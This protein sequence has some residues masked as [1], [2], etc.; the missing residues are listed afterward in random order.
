MT[1]S[2]LDH[3]LLF[4]Y[5]QYSNLKAGDKHSLSCAVLMYIFRGISSAELTKEIRYYFGKVPVQDF[6]AALMHN[7][8]LLRNVKAYLLY[9]TKRDAYHCY[10]D[11]RH[12][13]E[14]Y[15]IRKRDISLAYYLILSPSLRQLLL[16]YAKQYSCLSLRRI[17]RNLNHITKEVEVYTKKFV[18]RKLRFIYTS[19]PSVEEQDLV[20]ELLSKGVQSVLTMYPCIESMQHAINI[21]KRSI[22][23]HG[24]NLILKSTSK[25]RNV[26]TQ[27]KEGHFLR[28]MVSYDA[29]ESNAFSEILSM[30]RQVDVSVEAEQLELH[31]SVKHLL[32]RCSPKKAKLIQ[33]LMGGYCPDFTYWLQNEKGMLVDN[34][35]YYNRLVGK[36]NVL[37]YVDTAMDFLGVSK[38][39]GHQF[40]D[41][42][43]TCFQ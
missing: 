13:A 27:D 40:I 9:C 11:A 12:L 3:L 39:K 23:N 14:F 17:E 8:Y 20:N 43:R 1:T 16:R 34:V 22:H 4:H 10:N 32:E 7:G 35:S 36:N 19:S 6:R 28:T 30:H 41:E 5:P 31:L 38:V 2:T 42:L 33:L 26:L 18:K 24:I 21:A 37:T 15:K 25:S 29:G